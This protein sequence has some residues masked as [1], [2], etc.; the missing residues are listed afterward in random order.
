MLPRSVDGVDPVRAAAHTTWMTGAIEK[1]LRA[2]P[3]GAIW[4]ASSL[5]SQRERDPART[6]TTGSGKVLI[7]TTAALVVAAGFVLFSL[8]HKSERPV[9]AAVPVSASGAAPESPAVPTGPTA[10]IA[11]VAPSA[12]HLA[13]AR[14][15]APASAAP[16]PTTDFFGSDAPADLR[17]MHEVTSSGGMLALPRMK[18]LYQLGKDHPGDARPHLL[19]A[20]DA[21]N[22]GWN[23]FAVSHY[24]RAVREDP[25]A[26]EDARMLKDLVSIA[27]GK[28][29]SQKAATAI[30]DIYGAAAVPAIEDALAAAG[31]K[32]DTNGVEKLSALSRAL[33]AKAP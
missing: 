14:A 30:T 2:R 3:R 8:L 6:N 25:R 4:A 27:S 12:T 29:E 21:V 23:G 15:A 5:M 11:L 10:P 19:M 13:V 28:S 31:D 20:E 7:W 18:E 16:L 17:K 9:A 24:E 32:G 33:S 22:R 26:R 1:R